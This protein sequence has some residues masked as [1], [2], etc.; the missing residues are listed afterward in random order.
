MR[1]GRT[2][3]S[4]A[5]CFAIGLRIVAFVADRGAWR[6]VRAD[7]EQRLEVTTVA[8]FTAGQ[9]EADRRAVEVRFEMDLC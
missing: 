2:N 3:S 5:R 6:N 9:I 8:F 1:N 4:F 7:I